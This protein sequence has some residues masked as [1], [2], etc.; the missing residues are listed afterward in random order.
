MLVVV[1]LIVPRLG[2]PALTRLMLVAVALRLLSGVGRPRRLLLAVLLWLPRRSV[3][4]PLPA[5]GVTR[6]IGPIGTD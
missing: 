4:V 3:I 1:P 5:I 2:L 6:M